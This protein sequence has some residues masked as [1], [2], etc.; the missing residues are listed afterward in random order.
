MAFP[1]RCKLSK[2]YFLLWY[3]LDINWISSE[4]KDIRRIYQILIPSM[5]L[6]MNLLYIV[7]L[8]ILF[9]LYR[10]SDR[11]THNHILG[12]SS[13]NK[14]SKNRT[15]MMFGFLLCCQRF[16]V[17]KSIDMLRFFC[18]SIYRIFRFPAFIRSVLI[19]KMCT[20]HT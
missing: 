5:E 2:L 10:K 16:W 19:S 6:S 15:K 8:C 14:D 13:K 4:T 20:I 1:L 17:T 7:K 3:L 11:F 9:C 12:I 18:N